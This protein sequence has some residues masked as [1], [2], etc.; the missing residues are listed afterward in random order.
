[1]LPS[2]YHSSDYAGIDFSYGGFYYGY[3]HS[4]CKKCGG[5]NDGEYCQKCEGDND[6]EW[7]F[8]ATI[9]GK[10]TV[11]K[12]S[13]LGSKDMFNVVECLNVGIAMYM[14]TLRNG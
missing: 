2:F 1:M 5:K 12:F 4:V 8:V 6:R 11:I 14:E 13:D 7:C 3:E 10:E 9:D